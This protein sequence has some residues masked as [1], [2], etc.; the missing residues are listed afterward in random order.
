MRC[1]RIAGALTAAVLVGAAGASAKPLAQP[2]KPRVIKLN[3]IEQR[4]ATYFPIAMTFRVREV[5]LGKKAWS[6]RASLT[7]RSTKAIRITRH[8]E[9]ADYTLYSFALGVPYYIQAGISKRPS[10]T[11]LNASYARPTFP[12]FPRPGKSWSGVFGGPGLPPR[13]KLINVV[14]GVFS[15][16]GEQEWS[17]ITEHAFKR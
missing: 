4:T 3:W 12:T 6:V 11:P 15:V 5:T 7:N 16:P 9:D 17:W 14:F 13:G 1:A 10:L 8:S 2:A